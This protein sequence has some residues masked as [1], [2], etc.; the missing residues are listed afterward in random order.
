MFSTSVWTALL[1]GVTVGLLSEQG[2]EPRPHTRRQVLHINLTPVKCFD[3][4]PKGSFC[5][6][7]NHHLCIASFTMDPSKFRK[8]LLSGQD[9][10]Q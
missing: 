6:A 4:V 10:I 7:K 8:F 2:Q 9:K 1:V 3:E 5:A